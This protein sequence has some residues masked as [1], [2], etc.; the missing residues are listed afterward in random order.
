LH[1]GLHVFSESLHILRQFVAALLHCFALGAVLDGVIVDR[2]LGF[3]DAGREPG[4]FRLG[5]TKS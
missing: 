3:L 4:I 5:Y 2:C 1:G